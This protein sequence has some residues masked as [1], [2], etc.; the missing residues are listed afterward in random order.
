MTDRTKTLVVGSPQELGLVETRRGF[1]RMLGVGGTIVLLP[2][3]F[4]ACDDDDDDNGNGTGAVAL[5]LR[6][7]IGILNYAF[8]L[9]QLEAAFYT[10]VVTAANF[11]TLFSNAGERELL[12]DLRNHEVIHREFF[13]A[14]LGG[15]AISNLAVNFGNALASRDSILDAAITFEDTGVRA[16]N[17]AGKYLTRAENLLVAGKIVSVEARHAAAVRD[18]RD[19]TGTAFASAPAINA[20]GVEEG[21]EPSAVLPLVDPFI[22]TVVTISNQPA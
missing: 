3:V 4:T 9:E 20:Q 22:T 14:A 1:L 17:G 16:Y 11:N 7:D 2:S 19:T 21:L 10:Q 15:S 8:A 13:R 6:T 5:D 18:V 12:T